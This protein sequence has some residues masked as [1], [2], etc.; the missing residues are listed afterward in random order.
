MR[1]RVAAVSVGRIV[2]SKFSGRMKR[3]DLPCRP[4]SR[5]SIAA[6]FNQILTFKMRLQGNLVKC[7]C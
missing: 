1:Q 5:R 3:A 7:C 4:A 6:H 2:A